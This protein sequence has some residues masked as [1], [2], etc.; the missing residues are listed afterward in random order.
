[1]R[2]KRQNAEKRVKV[3]LFLEGSIKTVPV[4]C[5]LNWSRQCDLI[6]VIDDRDG[7]RPLLESF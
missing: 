6:E 1:M 2:S 3:I 7:Q 5:K 4:L